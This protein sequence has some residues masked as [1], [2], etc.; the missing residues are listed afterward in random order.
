MIKEIQE[1]NDVK[2]TLKR[3]KKL[4]RKRPE[5]GKE[6]TIMSLWKQIVKKKEEV[7]RKRNK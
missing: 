7:N 5:K 6:L 2:K 4:E 1:M 3:I